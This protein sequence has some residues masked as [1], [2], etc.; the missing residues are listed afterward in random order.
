M[1]QGGCV[2]SDAQVIVQKRVFGKKDLFCSVT[3][4][5]EPT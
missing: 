2:E 4:E 1:L 5:P 3:E